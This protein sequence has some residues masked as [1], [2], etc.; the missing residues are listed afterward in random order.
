M[1]NNMENNNGV[2]PHCGYCPHCGRANMQPIF[3]PNQPYPPMV[4]T[5]PWNQPIWSNVGGISYP[6]TT[7]NLPIQDFH[8]HNIC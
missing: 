2:C 4:P 1:E 3:I 5:Y 7:T 8:R 6:T